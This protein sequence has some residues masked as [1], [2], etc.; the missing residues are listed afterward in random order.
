[1]SELDVQTLTRHQLRV[2]AANLARGAGDYLDLAIEEG[3]AAE[4]ASCSVL[5]GLAWQLGQLTLVAFEE[6][7]RKL[8]S[9]LLFVGERCLLAADANRRLEMVQTSFRPR[10]LEARR[11]VMA[12]AAAAGMPHP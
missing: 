12:A 8:L 3:A 4:A 2:G 10:F 9:A 5:A 1:M 11:L 6:P 7:E